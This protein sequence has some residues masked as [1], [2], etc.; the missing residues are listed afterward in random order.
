MEGENGSLCWESVKL[1]IFEKMFDIH[2]TNI[3]FVCCVKFIKLLVRYTR[4]QLCE[5]FLFVCSQFVCFLYLNHSTCFQLLLERTTTETR[6]NI[7]P[8]S[9]IPSIVT[10]D[11]LNF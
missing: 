10:C 3:Y 11:L 4:I 6:P 1:R 7:Y 9:M 2:G 5:P 8:F